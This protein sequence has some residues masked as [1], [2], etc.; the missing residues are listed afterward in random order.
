MLRLGVAGATIVQTINREN[1]KI[2]ERD[3]IRKD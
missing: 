3:K 1:D 2:G